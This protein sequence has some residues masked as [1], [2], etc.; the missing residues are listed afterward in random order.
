MEKQEAQ[1]RLGVGHC[2]R[3]HGSI[4][5]IDRGDSLTPITLSD[6]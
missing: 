1:T 4:A 6:V 5:E 2:R 3:S